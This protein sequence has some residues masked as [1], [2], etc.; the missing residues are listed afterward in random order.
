MEWSKAEPEFKIVTKT[1][2]YSFS[3]IFVIMGITMF[4]NSICFSHVPGSSQFLS[5]IETP[6]NQT[7]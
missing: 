5:L 6:R 1:I 2:F 7:I 3:Y 4:G